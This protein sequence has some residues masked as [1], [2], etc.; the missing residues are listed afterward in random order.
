MCYPYTGHLEEG[1]FP[2]WIG[3]FFFQVFICS[4]EQSHLGYIQHYSVEKYV[5]TSPLTVTTQT[6]H[7]IPN[8]LVCRWPK[9]ETSQHLCTESSLKSHFSVFVCYLEATCSTGSHSVGSVSQISHPVDLMH[10]KVQTN[11]QNPGFADLSLWV[12]T[13]ACWKS[14]FYWKLNMSA[15]PSL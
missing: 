8:Y 6:L 7:L 2:V 15:Q 14:F 3:I 5:G 1:N 9:H 4:T 13:V 10:S 12:M 11:K